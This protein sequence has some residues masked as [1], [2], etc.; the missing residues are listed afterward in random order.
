MSEKE[1]KEAGKRFEVLRFDMARNAHA[2]EAR[3]TKGF[4]KVLLEEETDQILGAAYFG[5]G[6]ADLIHVYSLLMVAGLPAA[7]LREAVITHPTYAE[8]VQ[9][10]LLG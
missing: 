8:G 2:D 1:A 3:E 9:N 10:I 5:A 7:T 4:I 6:G